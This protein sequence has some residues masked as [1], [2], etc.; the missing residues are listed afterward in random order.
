MKTAYTLLGLMIT[1]A[2]VAQAPV[3]QG[4]G[5]NPARPAAE[6]AFKN[7]DTNKDSFLSKTEIS[8]TRIAD[9]FDKLDTNKDGKLSL[10]EYKTGREAM[11][12]QGPH[13]MDMDGHRGQMQGPNAEARF[14]ERDTNNDGFLSKTEVSSRMVERFD[15]MDTNKDGKLSLDEMKANM[16]GMG[17][18]GRHGE[19]TQ[20]AN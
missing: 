17:K 18:G 19:A 9:A 5:P 2:V 10:A 14:K 7:R 11:Q 1:C 4:P 6:E 16:Q 12:G 13:G 20:K 3:N 8:G 15:A